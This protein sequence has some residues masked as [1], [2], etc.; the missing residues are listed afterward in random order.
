MRDGGEADKRLKLLV[1][2]NI[3]GD[4]YVDACGNL[5][6]SPYFCSGQIKP[7]LLNSTGL[8]GTEASQ[9]GY[10]SA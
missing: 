7:D 2:V 3:S 4:A 6:L 9:T 8:Q 5:D 10:V 1:L